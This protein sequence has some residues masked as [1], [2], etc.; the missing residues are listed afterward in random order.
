MNISIFDPEMCCT[1]G[2]CGTSPD[3]ELVRVGE[4]VE[5]LK[6]QGH[7]VVRHMMSRDP[8]A[9]V[10]NKSVYD[11]VLKAGVKGLPVVTVDGAVRTVGHYPHLDELLV[12]KESGR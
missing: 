1:T 11:I 12:V 10:A 4:M 5:E 2:V 9:F 8:S 7:V 6:K 3:P